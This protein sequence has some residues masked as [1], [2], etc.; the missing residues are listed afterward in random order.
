M[1]EQAEYKYDVYISYSEA[2]KEWVRGELLLRL[3]G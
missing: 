2:D 3:D 1:T